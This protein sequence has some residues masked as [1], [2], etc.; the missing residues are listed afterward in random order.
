MASARRFPTGDRVRNND[1]ARPG[2]LV[3]VSGTGT[4][5]GKTWVAAE[6]L[7]GLRA[8]GRSV[9][10]RKPAQSFGPDDG[11]S[12]A[13][14]L[15]EASGE[16]PETVCLPHRSYEVAMAPFMAADSLGRA[17]FTMADLIGEVRWPPAIDI[18]IVEAAGGARS[19]ITSDGGDTVDL[20][21][22]LAPELVVVVADAGLGTINAVRMTAP[23][24]AG[25]D[26]VVHLNR[27][28]STN[29]LHIRNRAWLSDNGPAPVT[30]EG[31]ELL[32][33]VIGPLP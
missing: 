19:P 5:V 32:E 7:R 23:L 20:A 4:E 13:A 28:D 2:R 22:A 10:A 9:A 31:D 33:R 27:F 8:S 14:V 16:S 29:D 17:P 11:P 30:V 1:G 18:G 26:V 12:D 3:L 24:F 15:A 25:G 6:L 21:H